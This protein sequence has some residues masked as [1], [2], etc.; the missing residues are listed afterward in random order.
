MNMKKINSFNYVLLSFVIVIITSACEDFLKPYGETGKYNDDIVWSNP[1]FAE[2]ILLRAYGLLPSDYLR[3]EDFGSDDAVINQLDHTMIDLATGGWSARSNPLDSYAQTYNAMLH[4]N[5]FLEKVDSVVWSSNSALKDSLMKRRL[6]GEAYG[7]RAYYGSLLLR[8]VGGKSN[9]G[10]L[11]GY[12]IVTTA[13]ID[14]DKAQLPRNLY[15]ECVNQIIQDC[16]SAIKL[17]PLRWTDTGLTSDERDVIGERYHNRINGITA[18]LIKARVALTA[19]SEAFK[20][21]EIS[22]IEAAD[23][24]ADIIRLNGFGQFT[25]QDMQFYLQARNTNDLSYFSGNSEV[26]WYSNI[27][28]RTSSRESNYLPP[29]LFGKGLVSPSQNLVNAFGDFY[30]SPIKVSAVYDPQKPYNLRDPRFYMYVFFNGSSTE[31]GDIID[32]K[33]GD[34]DAIGKTINST[35]T[36]YYMR[37]L[38]DENVILTPGLVSGTPHF[39]VYARYT[40]ALLIFAEAANEVVGPDGIIKGYSAR[41]IIKRIRNR[42]GIF[43]NAYVDSLDKEG[44]AKLIRNERRIEL[45]FEGFRFWDLRRWNDIVTLNEPIHGIDLMNMSHFEVEKRQFDPYMIYGPIPFNET[46]KYDIEQNVGWN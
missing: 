23:Y 8:N 26:F 22:M 6:K 20:D 27:Q 12:P 15:R 39:Y 18:M 35:R 7:L 36:G 42:A 41:E 44:M 3:L 34:K 43:A 14:Y 9:S 24:A 11:L 13:R 19:A 1:A 4:I 32:I 40:E 17:L 45:C 28:A 46:L 25:A 2:G 29:S 16:D 33:N 31:K 30:G 37:K 5:L 21:S 38:M 10:K